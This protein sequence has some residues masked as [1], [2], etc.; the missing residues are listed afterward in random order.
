MDRPDPTN[1]ALP[2]RRFPRPHA[3]DSQPRNAREDHCAHSDIPLD[4]RHAPTLMEDYL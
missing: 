3:E 2:R 4:A 1:L